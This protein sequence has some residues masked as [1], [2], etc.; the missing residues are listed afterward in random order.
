MVEKRETNGWSRTGKVVAVLAG[1]AA[2]LTSMMGTAWWASADRTE[3]FM[4][5]ERL[6]DNQDD[7]ESRLRVV[8]E[9][10]VDVRI[11]RAEVADIKQRLPGP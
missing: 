1:V 4:R 2:W 7:H 6:E 11:I 10:R 8:E 5:I 9:I 3:A